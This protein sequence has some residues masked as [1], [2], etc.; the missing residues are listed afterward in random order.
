MQ[1]DAKHLKNYWN[2]GIWV[3]IGE[4]LVRAFRWKPFWQGFVGYQKSLHPCALVENSHNIG[5]VN[6]RVFSVNSI[7]LTKSSLWYQRLQ[8][9]YAWESEVYSFA[10]ETPQPMRKQML[11]VANLANTKWC[12]KPEKWLKPWHMGTHLR[13]L[14]ISESFPMNSTANQKAEETSD[15]VNTIAGT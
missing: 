11:L 14:M 6:I 1:N 5:S 2:P 8:R 9:Y 4:Y 3:L 7:Y 12:R 15:R 10:S 13:V